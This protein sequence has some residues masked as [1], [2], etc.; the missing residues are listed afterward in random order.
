MIYAGD[1][2]YNFNDD[3]LF[4]LNIN[5][6]YELYYFYYSYPYLSKFSLYKIICNYLPL[7]KGIKLR[8]GDKIISNNVLY[9]EEDNIK[10]TDIFKNY[11]SLIFRK[12]II[13]IIIIINNYN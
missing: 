9:S 12:K 11:I 7:S 13:F 5:G 3:K 6:H 2:D 8:I 10:N 1:S 4:V